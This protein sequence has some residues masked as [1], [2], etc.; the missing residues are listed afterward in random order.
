MTSDGPRLLPV[1]DPPCGCPKHPANRPG[2]AAQLPA[3][4]GAAVIAARLGGLHPRPAAA[5]PLGGWPKTR[6][7]R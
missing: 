2:P 4:M 3:G 5:W 6:R 1:L 7:T